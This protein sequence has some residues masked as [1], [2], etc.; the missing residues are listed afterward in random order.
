MLDQV[1]TNYDCHWVSL[2]T[3]NVYGSFWM[4]RRFGWVVDP[5]RRV[6][7][8]R[9]VL[10][11]IGTKMCWN[12]AKGKQVD[13]VYTCI[14]ICMIQKR[15]LC[16][17]TRKL[18][19][20]GRGFVSCHVISKQCWIDM[21]RLGNVRIWIHIVVVPPLFLPQLILQTPNVARSGQGTVYGNGDPLGSWL[22]PDIQ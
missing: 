4:F 8:D 19:R 21:S 13:V 16:H 1:G 7:L 9:V 22:P 17:N 6:M 10:L 2:G 14:Y 12:H 18:L 15:N 3:W 5:T 11:N 20:Y